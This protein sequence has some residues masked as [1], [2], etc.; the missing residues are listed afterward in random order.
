M[1]I[2]HE[3]KYKVAE[4]LDHAITTAGK[5][6]TQ[7]GIAEH[8]G[9]KNPNVIYMFKN[10][11]T[12]IPLDKAGRVAEA[13]SIDPQDFWFTCFKEYLPEAFAEYERVV[14]QPVLNADEIYLIKLLRQNQVDIKALIK[15]HI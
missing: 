6:V 4:I 8:A 11:L 1:T 10:G 13:V 2:L 12:K 15:E 3:G 9:F 5:N 7:R 14:K